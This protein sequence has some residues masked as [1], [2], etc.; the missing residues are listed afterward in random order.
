MSMAIDQILTRT[1]SASIILQRW[2]FPCV[3]YKLLIFFFILQYTCMR[4]VHCDGFFEIQYSGLK[5]TYNYCTFP[6]Y[7]C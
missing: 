3:L 7:L 4:D 6:I 5:V 2:H 1:V